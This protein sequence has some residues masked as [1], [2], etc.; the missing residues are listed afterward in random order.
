MHNGGGEELSV[1]EELNAGGCVRF[2]SQSSATAVCGG[3]W[4]EAL[5]QVSEHGWAFRET[6]GVRG[7]EG[8]ESVR[9]MKFPAGHVVRGIAGGRGNNFAKTADEYLVCGPAIGGLAARCV[10]RS[11]PVPFSGLFRERA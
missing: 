9:G 7:G 4:L 6:A 11:S 1:F 10:G 3:E 5:Q 8:A 2:G